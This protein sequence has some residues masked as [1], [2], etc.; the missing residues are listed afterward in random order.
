MEFKEK[1]FHKLLSS[2][3]ESVVAILL[4]SVLFNLLLFMVPVLIQ[5]IINQ[6]AIHIYERP[7]MVLFFILAIIVF[8]ISA[9]KLFQVKLVENLQ[10]RIYLKS[11]KKYVDF[12]SRCISIEN[13]RYKAQEVFYHFFEVFSLK[14][15][16]VKTIVDA[17]QFF[18][19]VF[20][21]LL[22]VSFYHL[23][24]FIYALLLSIVLYLVIKRFRK[25]A[26]ESGFKASEQKYK[27]I[28]WMEQMNLNRDLFFGENQTFFVN[29]K[30][31][32]EVSSYMEKQNNFFKIFYEQTK[33]F[34]YIQ[35]TASI[36]LLLVGGYLVF[37]EDLSLGQLIAAELIITSI[38]IGFSK[39]PHIIDDYYDSIIS[40]KKLF[41][42]SQFEVNIKSG[43]KVLDAK[44]HEW[45]F[46]KLD[47][48]NYIDTEAKFFHNL[49]LNIPPFKKVAL[50]AP[51][52]RGKTTVVNL[53]MKYQFPQSGSIKLNG[54][55]IYSFENK[56][57]YNEVC[58]VNND[59]CFFPGTILEN[60]VFGEK[61]DRMNEL[62]E[63]LVKLDLKKIIDSFPMNLE[64]NM[65]MSGHPFSE[66][67]RRILMLA[68]ALYQKPKTLIIDGLFD[69]FDSALS[70]KII[71]VLNSIDC[72]MLITTSSS[73]IA[74]KFD[75][76]IDWRE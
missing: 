44:S 27:V 14:K 40:S 7:T 63:I 24:F 23:A 45:C 32:N 46:E 39:L 76:I 4:V 74:E 75:S 41:Q 3:R 67:H 66:V 73:S 29:S 22:I 58:L 6:I 34:L 52:G 26:I 15:S 55:S 43:D 25:I 16:F 68:R 1:Y 53:M 38:L 47:V 31:E 5:V 28:A 51:E 2:E 64:T 12:F 18:L 59:S 36:S 19:Q 61:N 35:A 21:G 11:V 65:K 56:K 42:T 62:H 69:H 48:T 33:Y 8:F 72:T 57:F 17:F 9:L 10:R 70:M 54:E 60:L 30:L 50:L 49:S 13:E 71:K 37:R 20:I